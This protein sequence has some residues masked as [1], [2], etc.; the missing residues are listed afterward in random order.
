MSW[1][2]SKHN[3]HILLSQQ[4]GREGE[5]R[6]G[7]ARDQ[8][9]VVNGLAR[10]WLCRL[11][12]D[13]HAFCCPFFLWPFPG[14]VPFGPNHLIALEAANVD[15]V[16]NGCIRAMAMHFAQIGDQIEGE[17]LL[18]KFV[19]NLFPFEILARSNDHI[20]IQLLGEKRQH[21]E[22]TAL[23]VQWL[24]IAIAFVK[25]ADPRCVGIAR[26]PDCTLVTIG[27][28]LL[29]A[30]WSWTEQR[31][32]SIVVHFNAVG[33]FV[34][35][36]EVGWSQI[37]GEMKNHQEQKKWNEQRRVKIIDDHWGRTKTK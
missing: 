5:Q 8:L 24:E 29:K 21:F 2:S 12:S 4:I 6:M 23:D 13:S 34:V 16:C 15:H 31:R 18:A 33:N 25:T 26:L 19:Q 1:A 10:K 37:N 35:T 7:M 22:L 3:G 36:T 32:L 14:L 20:R 27:I 28:S 17:H 30:I 11:F 9:S